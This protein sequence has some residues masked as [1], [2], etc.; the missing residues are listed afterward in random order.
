VSN[1]PAS[2]LFIWI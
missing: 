2:C 1:N